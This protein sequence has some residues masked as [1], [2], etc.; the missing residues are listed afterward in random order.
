MSKAYIAWFAV[1][2]ACSFGGVV[3]LFMALG[4]LDEIK[5][6]IEKLGK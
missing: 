6:K 2:V 5:E 4:V 1:N 3:A